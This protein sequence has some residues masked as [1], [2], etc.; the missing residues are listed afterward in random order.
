MA[1]SLH[2]AS[3]GAYLQTLPALLGLLDKAADHCREHGL[4]EET[5]TG[6][7]LA[8][9]MWDF[10]KQVS[11]CVHLSAH[12]IDAIDAGVFSPD[13]APAP[14]TFAALRQDVADAIATLEAVS[15]ERIDSIAERDM[16]FEFR[17]RRMDFTVEDFLL[18]FSLPNFYFHATTAYAILRHRGVKLGK[19]DY[20]GA[21]RT[22]S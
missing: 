17:T 15:P 22:K 5:L 16:R 2:T 1:V 4:A 8:D 14:Q 19:G 18:S 9:D 13:L 12:V 6:A 3:I 21:L 7:S 11:Q 20:L 10:A